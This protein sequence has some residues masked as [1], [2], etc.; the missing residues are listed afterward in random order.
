MNG[1]S[2]IKSLQREK[3]ILEEE[4]LEILWYSI[5]LAVENCE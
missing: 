1:A 2:Q 3:R 4:K 5:K